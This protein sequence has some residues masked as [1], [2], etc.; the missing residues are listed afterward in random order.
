MKL[1]WLQSYLPMAFKLSHLFVH[2]IW[3]LSSISVTKKFI[4]PFFWW[5]LFMTHHVYRKLYLFCAWRHLLSEHLSFC[6]TFPS[7]WEP[8][9]KECHKEKSTT[10]AC[11]ALPCLDVSSLILQRMPLLSQMFESFLCF[12]STCFKREYA[13]HWS[14]S[15]NKFRHDDCQYVHDW[16]WY[17]SS[18]LHQWK[19]TMGSGWAQWA[20]PSKTWTGPA[21]ACFLGHDHIVFFGFPY[22]IYCTKG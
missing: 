13:F 7:N 3:T 15:L 16:V 9:T 20:S 19:P 11:T 12:L 18:S 21:R 2:D 10:V 14:N 5:C 1:R 6:L 22:T 8:L 4:P 17:I